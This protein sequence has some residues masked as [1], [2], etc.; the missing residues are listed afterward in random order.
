MISVE[1]DCVQRWLFSGEK[2]PSLSWTKH[3]GVIAS[4]CHIPGFL[5]ALVH[6]ANQKTALTLFLLSGPCARGH[7]PC[8]QVFKTQ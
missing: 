3:G 6:P 1:R 7:C 5:R 2:L 4:F 8:M